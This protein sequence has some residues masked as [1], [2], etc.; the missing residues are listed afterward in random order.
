MR[1]LALA[2]AWIA[3]AVLVSCEPSEAELTH[4]V[5]GAIRTILHTPDAAG[6]VATAEA[7]KQIGRYRPRMT[8]GV[9]ILGFDDAGE[10]KVFT[11]RFGEGNAF[12]FVLKE[13]AGE[14]KIVAVQPVDLVEGRPTL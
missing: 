14:T 3:C 12:W 7:A 8:G 5:D 6:T 1:V 4:W 11:V 2:L 13:V 9:S 10:E